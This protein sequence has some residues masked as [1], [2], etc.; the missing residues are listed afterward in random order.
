MKKLA[1]IVAE[2]FTSLRGQANAE[3]NRIKYLQD[4]AD[5]RVDVYSFSIY[6]GWLVRRLRHTPKIELSRIKS[7]SGVKVNFIWRAF[8]LIDYILSTKLHMSPI[9]NKGWALKYVD[10]FK[11]YDLIMAHSDECGE[12]ALAAHNKYGI[13]YCVTWHGSDIHTGPFS[14]DYA[15]ENTK[16][17][18]ENATVNFMVSRKLLQISEQISTVDNKVV[19]YNGINTDYKRFDED[20]RKYLRKKYN[21]ADKKVV[22]FAGNLVSIKNPMSL[23]EI[24]KQTFVKYH[25]LEFWIM[26]TG[27]YYESIKHKCDEYCIPVVFCGNVPSEE[28]PDRYNSIDVLVLP[29]VNEGLPL[30]VV[31]AMACGANVVGSKAGGIPEVI[32]EENAFE[33]DEHFAENVSNRI[34]KMLTEGVEQTLSPVFSWAATAKHENNIYH[35]IFEGKKI[36]FNSA[37][38]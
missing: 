7:I 23:P 9:I 29:S 16:V 17:I 35:N 33:R 38:Q 20:K 15:F 11:N 30:V 24:F 10:I 2:S 1:I 31:E 25:N 13:P 36:N 21:V 5:Y 37:N 22:A 14:S 12:L 32:G 27:K 26:G 3:L 28:M 34:I 4:I 6:E 8:S 19:L 18:L